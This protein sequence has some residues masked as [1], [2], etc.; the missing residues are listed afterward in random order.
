M[1]N[2]GKPYENPGNPQEN[3]GKTKGKQQ[4]HVDLMGL[5][6]DYGPT[7]SCGNEVITPPTKVTNIN[8]MR[9]VS[10]L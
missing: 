7:N 5:K 8:S 3:H 10:W 1:G 6:A 9:S 2:H 4:E